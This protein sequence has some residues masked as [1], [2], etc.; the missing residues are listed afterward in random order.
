MSDIDYQEL[1][2]VSTKDRFVL[3]FWRKAL[4]QL[5]KERGA[6]SAGQLAKFT[7]QSRNTAKKYLDRLVGEKC[8]GFEEVPWTTGILMKNYYPLKANPNA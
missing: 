3:E 8:V 6:V 7:G 5:Y 2:D 4:I 1:I